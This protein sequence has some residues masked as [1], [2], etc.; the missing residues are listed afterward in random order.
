MTAAHI[1]LGAKGKNGPPVANLFTGPKKEGIFS[2]TLADGTLTDENL[3]GSL[4][5]KPLSSLVDMIKKGNAYVNVHTDKYP[6]G[7]LR[8]QIK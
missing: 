7:E 6:D 1:H 8:G 4:A 2:G 3:M 5:G